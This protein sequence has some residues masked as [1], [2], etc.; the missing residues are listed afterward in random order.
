MSMKIEFWKKNKIKNKRKN[1]LKETE[2]Y[3]SGKVEDKWGTEEDQ[4]KKKKEKSRNN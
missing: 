3:Q 4:K 1:S 2:L